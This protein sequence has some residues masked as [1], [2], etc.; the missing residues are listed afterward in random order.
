MGRKAEILSI[1]NKYYLWTKNPTVRNCHSLWW[2]LLTSDSAAFSE[3]RLGPYSVA[4]EA[5]GTG[6][7]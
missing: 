4:Y 1:E 6:G 2:R 7:R 5:W 3:N